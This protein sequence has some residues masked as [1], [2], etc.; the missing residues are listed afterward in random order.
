MSQNR[1]TRNEILER[2][3]DMVDSPALSQKERPEGIVQQDAMCIGWLQDA[4]DYVH[5]RY[6]FGATIASGALAFVI[7]TTSYSVPSNYL[8]D[9]RDGVRIM[10]TDVKRRLKRRSLQWLLDQDSATNATTDTPHSYVITGPTLRI[11]PSPNKAYTGEIWYYS[12]PTVLTA[13]TVPTYPDDWSLVEYVRLRGTEWIG[14]SQ[15]GSAMAYLTNIVA[16]L[17]SSGLGQEAEEDSFPLD[18]GSYRQTGTESGS[19]Y[20]WLGDPVSR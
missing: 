4:L 7:G 5:R 19:S 6:P 17:R 8:L 12:L 18:R 3:L 2:A 14:Q 10:Q 11:Y 9:V 16:G 20:G 15:P 13:N 1:M